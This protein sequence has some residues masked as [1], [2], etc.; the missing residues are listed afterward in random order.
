MEIIK[1]I[2]KL[3]D[4]DIFMVSVSI[5]EGDKIITRCATSNFAYADIPIATS[6]MNENI[7]KLAVQLAP[8]VPS[9]LGNIEEIAEAAK[10]ANPD[11]IPEPEDVVTYAEGEE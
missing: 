2:S 9:V 11:N 3:T 8:A 1:D 5:K 10:A 7:K 4:K 6:D